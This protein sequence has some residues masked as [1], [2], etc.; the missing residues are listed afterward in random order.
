M[1]PRSLPVFAAACSLLL[2]GR[3]SALTL[4]QYNVAGNGTTNWSTNSLQV[5]AIGRQMLYWQPDIVTFNEIPR[6]NTWQ[7]ANFVTAYLPGYYLATNSGTDGFLRSAIASRHPI[8]RSQSWLDG[9]SLVPFGYTNSPSTYTR[10][11]FEAEIA[12]PGWSQPLHVFTTHLKATE[13]GT[14]F[15]N[16]VRRRAAEAGAISNF[17][18]TQFLP[19]HVQQPYLLSGDLNED[20]AQPPGPSGHPLE[21]ITSP[22]TGLRLTT[23]LNP[24]TSEASTYSI[25]A[26]PHE[27]IDYILPCGLLF[28]NV[29]ASQIFRTDKLSLMP[30]GLLATDSRTASDHLP[31]IMTFQNPYD[32]IPRVG[33]VVSSNQTVNLSWPTVPGRNYRVESSTNLANWFV[34]STNLFAATTN[35]SWSASRSAPRQFFRVQRLP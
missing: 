26:S 12:V 2:A 29:A 1:F 8:T 6:T 10:D 34:V 27:R 33:I 9:A 31:V 5:N 20:I 24:V 22:P 13:S 30:A 7:M 15:T 11:L 35:Q 19:A 28:S 23:S 25:R 18:V 3:A 4:L 21:K 14:T 17:F 32:P 16:S